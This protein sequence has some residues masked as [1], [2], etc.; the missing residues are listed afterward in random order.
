MKKILFNLITT[1]ILFGIVFTTLSNTKGLLL[2]SLTFVNNLLLVTCCKCYDRAPFVY[3]N[4]TEQGA[5]GATKIRP[6]RV[7]CWL[8]MP[9]LKKKRV[10]KICY[11]LPGVVPRRGKINLLS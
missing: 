7:K 4:R 2:V 8:K 1:L 11:L 3:E 9:N 6:A 10:D 5:H